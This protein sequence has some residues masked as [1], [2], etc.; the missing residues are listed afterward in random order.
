M[1]KSYYCEKLEKTL[2]FLPD[3][4]KFCCS[5]AQGPGI[6]LTDFSHIDKDKIISEKE[7]IRLLLE[8]GQIPKECEGCVEYKQRSFKEQLKKFFEKEEKK[9]LIRH[10]I[11]DH[12]KQCD[13]NCIYCSQR[14]IYKEIDQKY[15][16]LPIIKQL[17]ELKMIDETILKAEFQGGGIAALKEFDSLM[18]EFYKHGC[19]DFVILMNGIKYLPILEKIGNNPKSH[20][21]ISL[22]AGTKETFYKIKGIDAFEQTI[23]NIKTLRKKSQAHIALQYIVVKEINDNLDELKKFLNIVL[24]IGGIEPVSIEIDYRNTLLSQEKFII[25]KHYYDMFNYAEKFCIDNGIWY[26][27]SPYTRSIL[28]KGSNM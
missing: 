6:E 22:D 26:M 21:C 20:I 4:V 25:P 24:E 18:T 15:E 16:L 28:Q 11:V 17:Y 23:Q 9:Y 3:K 27:L 1:F 12:F 13:C 19:C 5:C 2:H 8:N 14:Y 10:V 7:R